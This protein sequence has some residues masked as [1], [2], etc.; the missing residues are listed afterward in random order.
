MEVVIILV[1]FDFFSYFC[2]VFVQYGPYAIKDKNNILKEGVCRLVFG[3]FEPEKFT[4]PNQKQRRGR[5]RAW[6]IT[7]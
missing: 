1:L 6:I 2:T 4:I 3:C 7:T 5:C